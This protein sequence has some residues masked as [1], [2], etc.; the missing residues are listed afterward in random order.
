MK[1]TDAI[2]AALKLPAG[3]T[4]AV[5]FDERRPGLGV[6]LRSSAKRSA[7]TRTWVVQCRVAGRSQRH[8]L[9]PTTATSTKRA[10]EL[11]D[12]IF[13]KVRRGVDPKAEKRA[14]HTAAAETFGILSEIFLKAARGRMRPSSYDALSH[15]IEKNLKAL[16]GEPVQ[17]INRKTIAAILT[18]LEEKIGPV[19]ANRARAALSVFFTWAMAEGL[20]EANPVFGTTK[21]PEVSRDRVLSAPELAAVWLACGDRQNPM[22]PPSDDYGRIVRLL[23]LTGQRRDEVGAM[24]ESELM[25]D[26]RMWSLPA[27]RTKNGRPHDVPLSDAAL[28]LLPGPRDDRA[29]LFGRGEGSFSGWSRCKERLDA[30]IA[31]ASPDGK[32]IAP[33]VV[34]D[35]RRSFHTGLGEIGIFPHVAEAILNHTSSA[36]SGKAG[37]AGVY[38]RASYAAEK[39]DAIDRWAAHVEKLVSGVASNVVALRPAGA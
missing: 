9:G 36:A 21:L 29:T 18:R 23:I 12:E 19:T 13:A 5:F 37:V 27:A 35:L 38:N 20:V 25:R 24:G 30:R 26:L 32:G 15:H 34:H 7:V 33:W 28:A 16:S 31:D 39:R 4:D 17:A 14:A 22:A 2:V 1:F 10:R 3:K 8:D 11:A 6:R